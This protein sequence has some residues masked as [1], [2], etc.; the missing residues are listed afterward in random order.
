MEKW[1][2]L[3]LYLFILLLA[4]I[5]FT[6]KEKGKVMRR[7]RV[8]KAMTI[9]TR[10]VQEDNYGICQSSEGF[11]AVLADGMGKNYGGK[12][13]SKIAVDTMKDMFA[14]YQAVENPAYFFQ[15]SFSRINNDILNQ[16]EEGR[17]GAS[18]GAVLIKDNF[19][20]YAVAGNVKL[21]VYRKDDLIPL[22]T[23][24]TID[25]L[26]EDRFQ[27][28]SIT[29]EDALQ[30]LENKRIYNYLGQD[31]FQEIEFFDT[32][33]R[34]KEK[35]LVVLMSD[36]LYEGTEWRTIEELLAGKKKCQQKALEIIEVIN[37]DSRKEKDNASIVLVEVC[38]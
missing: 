6:D 8:G 34:L 22:S 35:D 15:R 13:S 38:I 3:F 23:G 20:Y 1:M 33:V 5:R 27:K 25:M 36:G 10:Q 4:V 11:L 30:L 7:F 19:L 14:G 21:A 37:T 17:G 29:R 12:V 32:P 24:H 26:V 18:L 28:G 2:I 9:G 16:L 31:G